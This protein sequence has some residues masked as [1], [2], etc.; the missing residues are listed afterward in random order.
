MAH[1]KRLTAKTVAHPTLANARAA[2]SHSR[3]KEWS[4]LIQLNK[5]N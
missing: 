2:F 4:R 3:E 5:L 1:E